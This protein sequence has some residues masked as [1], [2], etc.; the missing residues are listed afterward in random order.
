MAPFRIIWGSI[1]L[2]IVLIV[3]LRW[4]PSSSSLSSIDRPLELF[5]AAGLKGPVEA[6]ARDFERITGQSVQIQFAGSGTLL[7][8]L[9]VSQRGDL[10]IPADNSFVDIGRSNHLLAEV[11]PLAQMSAVIVVP[12]GNPKAIHSIADLLRDDIRVSLGNPDSVAVG[13]ITRRA[14][15]QSGQWAALAAQATV[16][17]PTVND[18]ANDVKLGAVD[19]GIIWDATVALYPELQ[20]VPIPELAVP[21]AEVS[22]C[23]LRSSTQPSVALRFARFLAARDQ[24]LRHFALAGFSVA[25]GD[26]W[27][28]RPSVL[29]F[30]GAVNR[31]AIE[32]TLR[33]F[34]EREGVEITRVYNGCGILTAQIHSGQKPDAY[35]ACDVSFMDSVQ[36]QFQPA[37]ALAETSLVII[38]RK[39]NPSKISGLPDLARDGLKTGLCN[40]QQSAL[41]ALTARLLR[42]HGLFDAVMKRVA[43]QTPTA[44]L[45]LNQLR[46][47]AL[48]AAVVYEANASQV[49]ASV[50]T[51]PLSGPGTLAT[52]P[53]AVGRD[54]NNALLMQRLMTALQS[55]LARARFVSNGFRWKGPS[56]D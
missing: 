35:F 27:T 13:S 51:I 10:F 47:G 32:P 18:I 38:T 34:E 7:S 49:L 28:L 36:S 42:Q 31:S 48:D 29:L 33:E 56:G 53:Y 23:L 24:G 30:S 19:A 9:R 16:F 5:C 44:D 1:A 50:E 15:V 17:K 3:L 6:A 45:L 22:V 39:G 21:R 46:S 40:E 55:D 11:L 4:T 8:N 25:P 2:A 43:V 54:S 14:L 52:Q 41:G 37:V 26:L 12:K 20:A